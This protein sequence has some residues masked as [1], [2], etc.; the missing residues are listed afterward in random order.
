MISTHILDISSGSPASG[1]GVSLE[2][3][4]G[5]NWALIQRELTNADGRISYSCPYEPGIYRLTFEVA[6]YL[7]SQGKKPFFL[8]CPITFE[9]TDTSRKYHVPLLFSPFGLSTYRGS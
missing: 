3:K 7:S 4:S 8:D 6:A 9:V 5:Q 1:V 2:K